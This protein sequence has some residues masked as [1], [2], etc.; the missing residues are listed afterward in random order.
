MHPLLGDGKPA[1]DALALMKERGGKWAA[2]QNVAMDSANCGHLQ[3]LKYGDG[4]TYGK[5]PEI[6]P[7]DTDHGMGWR[8]RLVGSVDLETGDIEPDV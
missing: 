2:Y 3:F 4:C 5:P 6:Y 1:E 7:S 8:Y